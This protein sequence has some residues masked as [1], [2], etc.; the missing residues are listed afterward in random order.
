MYEVFV[1]PIG[2]DANKQTNKQTKP[3]NTF[4]ESVR[5][6]LKWKAE[7]KYVKLPLFT[8]IFEA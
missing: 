3:L 6:Q 5:G 7:T 8:D 1:G 4:E 2:S